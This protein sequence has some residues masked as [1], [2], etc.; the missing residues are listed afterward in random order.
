VPDVVRVRSVFTAAVVSLIAALL[1]AGASAG[2]RADVR[3]RPFVKVPGALDVVGPR[4]D[5]RLVVASNRG[6]FLMRRSGALRPFARGTTGYKPASGEAYVAL[7]AARRLSSAGCRF[8]QDDLYALDPVTAPGV[9]KI[10]RLGRGRR[11]ADLPAGSFLS[12]IAFDHVGRFGSRLLVSALV[13]NKLTLHAVDCRGRASV[14]LRDGPRVEGGMAVAPATF[15]RFAGQLVAADENSGRIFAFDRTGRAQLVAESGLAAGPDIGVESVGFVPSTFR[16][17][18]AAYMAD[19]GAPGAPTVGT[20]SLLTL[21]GADLLR[22]GVRAGDML[23][24]TEAGAVTIVVR[25]GR[26]CSVR[27]IATGPTMTHGEG[28][29]TFLAG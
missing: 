12:G 29:I 24:A 17:R 28:H 18:G 8:R 2:S 6:L 19:F 5:G 16:R 20:D 26:R 15:G 22:A 25:C 14:L 10:D 1:A 11:F 7:A 4:A 23:V 13:A 21:S 9:I 3:W 27:R